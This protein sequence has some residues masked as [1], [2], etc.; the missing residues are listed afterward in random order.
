MKP[1]ESLRSSGGSL[2]YFKPRPSRIEAR[3]AMVEILSLGKRPNTKIVAL[4]LGS[5][6]GDQL[7]HLRLGLER[8]RR[9][10]S[11][12]AVSSVY[13]SRPMYHVDQP[14]FLNAC[15]VG[16]TWL[17]PRQMLSELQDAERSAGRRRG[18]PRYGPRELDLDL[19]LYGEQV[20]ESEHLTLP[21]PR[22]T[23]RAFVLVPL[24][25]IAP[26]WVVAAAAD[27]EAVTVADLAAAVEKTGIERTEYEL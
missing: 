26:D 2:F 14:P 11:D 22:M 25:E 1:T 18:G 15:C 4:A 20:L 19:L 10:M 5:N 24:A 8:S 12:V 17:S 3:K 27:R 7:A 6:V 13:E 23:E 16:R 21:H 9:V